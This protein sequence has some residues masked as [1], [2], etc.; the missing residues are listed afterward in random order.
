ME[1]EAWQ[2]RAGH[3]TAVGP[4]LSVTM[5][6]LVATI[7]V[8]VVF[9]SR[10]NTHASPVAGFTWW[11]D[12]LHGLLHVSGLVAGAILVWV[13]TIRF[14]SQQ[15]RNV[16]E[17]G[18]VQII[19][20]QLEQQNILLEFQNAELERREAEL[21]LAKRSAEDAAR[22]KSE[23][24]ANMS[25]EIRTPMTA[26]LGFADLLLHD[27]ET[28][29]SRKQRNAALQAIYRNGE[30]L[31]TIVNDILDLSKIESA[32]MRCEHI[33]VSPDEVVRDVVV[34]MSDRAETKG[35]G[36]RVSCHP[37]VPQLILSD[38][39]R[40]RQILINL[41]GNAVK[42]TTEGEVVIGLSFE[43]SAET[44]GTLCI[45]VRDTG[46]GVAPEKLKML[47]DPFTQANASTTR[48][49]GGSG[50]GLAIS[51]RLAELL[52]GAIEVESTE[53][54]GSTFTLRV[55]TETPPSDGTDLESGSRP[56][57]SGRKGATQSDRVRERPLSG[58]RILLAEDGIDNQRL[59]TLILRKAGAE[60]EVVENGQ[61]AVDVGLAADQGDAPFDLILMDMQMPVMDGYCATTTLRHRGFRRPIIALTANAMSEER[62]KCLDVGC[63]DYIAKPIQR[64][65]FV[66]TLAEHLETPHDCGEFHSSLQSRCST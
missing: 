59:I 33:P 42:F 34:M 14:R 31:L 51:K 30:H 24:L 7:A 52:G 15:H 66:T 47:F 41:V 4:L 16:E 27:D 6:I 46:I 8:D 12:E 60:V 1:N 63:D 10:A 20:A 62:G 53:G 39:I 44:S 37:S 64:D 29:D 57:Y 32:G 18:S 36:R 40:L 50:L 43:R 49:F 25:H 45:S 61:E 17:T 26:I 56:G 65:H 3:S 23:F 28:S 9:L 22:A 13:A 2:G 19:Q 55:V 5:C 35:W 21:S 54:R 58:F 48:R 38:P 11:F